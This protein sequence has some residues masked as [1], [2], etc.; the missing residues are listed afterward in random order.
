MKALKSVSR[1]LTKEKLE[2]LTQYKY[3]DG[4]YAF[5]GRQK[6]FKFS[7]EPY[8]EFHEIDKMHYCIDMHFSDDESMPTFRLYI[9]NGDGILA[10]NGKGN[11]SKHYK[12]DTWYIYS[13][14]ASV[15]LGQA[16]ESKYKITLPNRKSINADKFM[17]DVND[18]A[19]DVVLGYIR[20]NRVSNGEVGNYLGDYVLY[21]RGF[22][23][24]THIYQKRLVDDLYYLKL[25]NSNGS[26]YAEKYSIDD[27]GS[28]FD[29]RVLVDLYL[30]REFYSSGDDLWRERKW[31]VNKYAEPFTLSYMSRQKAYDAPRLS[32]LKRG[33]F[34]DVEAGDD[35]KKLGYDGELI[36]S[37]GQALIS[38]RSLVDSYKE[39]LKELLEHRDETKYTDSIG[40]EVDVSKV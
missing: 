37:K 30:S 13:D 14:L 12:L 17:R 2:A 3:K 20:N 15:L 25:N 7:I 5:K 32:K 39:A 34:T 16:F 6:D 4:W 19:N 21:Y 9:N 24:L 8:E 26:L 31:F 10:A 11:A 1:L 36:T 35:M 40:D 38:K 28:M 18:E 22:T 27:L 23:R 33:A 29:T